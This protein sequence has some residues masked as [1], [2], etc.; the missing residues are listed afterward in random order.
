MNKENKAKSRQWR[1]A[2][3]AIQK[4]TETINKAIARHNRKLTG[5]PHAF[6]RWGKI[7]STLRAIHREIDPIIQQKREAEDFIFTDAGRHSAD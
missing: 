3:Q 1:I 4:E 6:A 5:N 2:Q 7:M